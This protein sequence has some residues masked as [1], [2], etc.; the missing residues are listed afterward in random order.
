[1][2]LTRQEVLSGDTVVL[3]SLGS[4]PPP[5]TQAYSSLAVQQCPP[6]GSQCPPQGSQRPQ[7]S[8]PLPAP[9]RASLPLH[10]PFSRCTCRCAHLHPCHDGF[11]LDLLAA[12]ASTTLVSGST[13]PGGAPLP[14]PPL[15]PPLS[16]AGPFNPAATLPPKLVK[17]ILDLDYVEMSEVTS[18]VAPEL[19]PGRPPPPSRPP[20]TDISQW[21]ERYA[22]MAAVLAA[23]FPTKAPEL[24]GYLATIVRAERNYEAGRWVSYDRQFRREAL[25][26]KDLNWSVTDTRL[27]SEAFTGRA[28][29]IPRCSICL[30]DDHLAQLCPQNTDRQWLAW[31]PGPVPWQAAPSAP[32][33][34]P[35]QRR[36]QEVCN[37]FNEGRCRMATC[38]YLHRCKR[39]GG[40]HPLLHCPEAQRR[41]RSPLKSTQAQATS[42]WSRR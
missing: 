42:G 16:T 8:Q 36:H 19:V 23:R 40:D 25:A 9:D 27:F 7:G 21:V 29:S 12:A 13:T 15:V 26:R 37:R 14:T 18:D 11:G 10:C 31:L 20:V 4:Q 34:P 41:P 17:R 39:C 28:R 1:M 3:L 2:A 38:R 6:Q 5:T 33:Q 35:H 22:V 30:R 24:F 32:T